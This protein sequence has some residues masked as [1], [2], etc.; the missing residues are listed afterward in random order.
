MNSQRIYEI[1]KKTAYPDSKSVYDALMQ[2]WNECTQT[3]V[4]EQNSF[5]QL[6]GLMYRFACEDT[7]VVKK[8]SMP[9][10]HHYVTPMQAYKHDTVFKMRIDL[11]AR[12]LGIVKDAVDK[13]LLAVARFLFP[14]RTEHRVKYPEVVR[15]LKRDG[16]RPTQ[17]II[18]LGDGVEPHNAFLSSW[19]NK[20]VYPAMHP[21]HKHS[22]II[23]V[24]EN[25][26]ENK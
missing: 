17:C 21:D 4:A 2:V 9:I 11:M 22:V 15:G 3:K 14:N 19:I 20:V 10:V 7:L 16:S 1:Q 26:D 13:D 5:E 25:N 24:W 23:K 18:G 8:G 6:V 12:E